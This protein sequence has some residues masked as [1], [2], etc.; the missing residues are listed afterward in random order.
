MDCRGS[1]PRCSRWVWW[2]H[3]ADLRQA[4][5]LFD[6]VALPG[7][8]GVSSSN[9][10]LHT[11]Y[12]TP[13]KGV[14]EHPGAHDGAVEG[15]GVDGDVQVC[16]PGVGFRDPGIHGVGAVSVVGFQ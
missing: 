8:D 1:P 6:S 11:L 2:G 16:T 9:T 5:G 10:A 3:P 4:G 12:P 13:T 7:D 14:T 15:V